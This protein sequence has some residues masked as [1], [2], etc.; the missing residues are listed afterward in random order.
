MKMPLLIDRS[1]IHGFFYP[2]HYFNKKFL[3]FQ[4]PMDDIFGYFKNVS[5]SKEISHIYHT[6]NQRVN[7]HLFS[8]NKYKKNQY[9]YN[10]NN[11]N[12]STFNGINNNNLKEIVLYIC[13]TV[14]IRAHRVQEFWNRIRTQTRENNFFG[15]GPDA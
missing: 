8:K 5:M 3:I 15:P 1:Q 4:F 12:S 10:N 2:F 11:N 6:S 13:Q 7:S 14:M 9:S